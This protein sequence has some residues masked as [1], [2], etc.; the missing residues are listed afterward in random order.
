MRYP[1]RVRVYTPG[2][3][4]LDEDTGR[5]TPG[6]PTVLYDGPGDVQDGGVVVNRDPITGTPTEMADAEL[7]VPG[8]VPVTT[9]VPE[10]TLVD[11]LWNPEDV[12]LAAWDWDADPQ[13]A[14]ADV[15]GAEVSKVIRLGGE[16]YLTLYERAG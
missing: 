16:V 1:H 7:F 3:P 8:A 15:Q 4:V 11:V 10:E 6:P 12:D 13:Q 9:W 2:E 14:G 5:F